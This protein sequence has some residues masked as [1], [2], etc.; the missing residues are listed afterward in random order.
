MY[1]YLCVIS[2]N[3]D[4]KDFYNTVEDVKNCYPEFV[5]DTSAKFENTSMG[6]ILEITNDQGITSKICVK[7]KYK[8]SQ[9][10]IMSETYLDEFFANREIKKITIASH[11]GLTYKQK[12]IYSTFFIIFNII[13]AYKILNF[14]Y[15]AIVVLLI[16]HM[17]TAF[18]FRKKFDLSA[19]KI[20]WVQLGGFWA[21]ILPFASFVVGAIIG[22]WD[23]LGIILFGIIY[24]ILILPSL[25]FCAIIT[26]ITVKLKS[27]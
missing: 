23:G 6:Q 26:S 2:D 24:F 13:A 10:F 4:K 5:E 15:V 12:I 22:D 1:K 18:Y 11:D 17:I 25:F 3:A 7:F 20:L 14:N 8:A 9:L 27:K 21:V 16:S 19:L